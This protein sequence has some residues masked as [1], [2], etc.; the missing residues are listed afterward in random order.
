MATC[1]LAD[2]SPLLFSADV[3]SVNILARLAKLN[4]IHN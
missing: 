4:A 2:G 1:L 3:Y